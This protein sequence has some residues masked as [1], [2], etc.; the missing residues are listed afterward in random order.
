MP[1]ALKVF[2]NLRSLRAAARE[3]TIDQL[4][5]M[6]EKFQ[7][8][9]A[10]REEVEAEFEAVEKERNEKLEKYRTMLMQDG[11]NPEDLMSSMATTKQKSKRAA[12]PAKYKFI[13][14]DGSEKTWTGQG[15]TPKLIKDAMDAGEDLNQ[16]LI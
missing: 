15:R 13:D 8:V 1:E 9:V 6:L 5:E 16:F 2:T 4:Q 11:I 10:E 3:H 12:R 14:T 7:I